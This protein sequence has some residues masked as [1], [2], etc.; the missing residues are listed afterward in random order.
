M[1]LRYCL[2]GL[3]NYG[4]MTGY[5][6]DKA[7]KDSLYPVCSATTSQVYRELADMEKREW[8]TSSEVVQS[9]KPNR[10]VY[11]ITAAGKEELR[12]WLLKDHISE[13]MRIKHPFYMQM[14]FA[15]ENSIEENIQILEHM[16]EVVGEELQKAKLRESKIG[17]YIR[18]VNDE[19]KSIYWEM[20]GEFG[21]TYYEQLIAW[22]DRSI[23]RL[24]QQRKEG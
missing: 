15:G 13:E 8:L 12:A 4:G 23:H 20:L 22:A 21:M 18:K 19:S 16:K 5:E 1:S 6:L 14:F 17:E 24:K 2:L 9:G 3:I 10:R 7:F 11:E